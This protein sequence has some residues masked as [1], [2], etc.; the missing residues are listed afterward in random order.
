[1]THGGSPNR[2]VRQPR[3]QQAEERHVYKL[4]KPE[5]PTQ[6]PIEAMPKQR[7]GVPAR[8]STQAWQ[9]AQGGRA[10]VEDAELRVNLV[11]ELRVAELCVKVRAEALHYRLLAVATKP[12]L[13]LVA[14]VREL[15]VQEL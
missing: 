14:A 13:V 1:M 6:D 9:T 8:H 7:S 4:I 2:R 3:T 11:L 5:N 12:R 10:H 15:A